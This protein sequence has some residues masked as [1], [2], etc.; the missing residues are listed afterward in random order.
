MANETIGQKFK[1]SASRERQISRLLKTQ[2]Q[3]STGAIAQQ[4]APLPT[5]RVYARNST[6]VLLDF[7]DAAWVD[8]YTHP[9]TTIRDGSATGVATLVVLDDVDPANPRYGL[10]IACEPIASNDFGIVAV[11]GVAVCK[12]LNTGDGQ[13]LRPDGAT[14]LTYDDWGVARLIVEIDTDF[15]VVDLSSVSN[16]YHRVFELT[17]AVSMGSSSAADIRDMDDTTVIETATVYDPVGM[18]DGLAI[19]KKGICVRQNGKYYIIQAEC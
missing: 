15:A 7:G 17:A 18:F 6:G 11:A 2:R 9:D 12:H 5:G 3:Q 8:D 14:G 19:G 4:K 16:E 13:W 1:P 10:A